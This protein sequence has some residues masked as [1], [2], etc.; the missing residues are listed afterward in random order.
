MLSSVA[1][2]MYVW[3]LQAGQCD[4]KATP[5]IIKESPGTGHVDGQNA[6]GTVRKITPQSYFLDEKII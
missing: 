4:G 5:T 2:E 3:E 6:I 1:I